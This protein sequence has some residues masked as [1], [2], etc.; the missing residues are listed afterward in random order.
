M[1]YD[2]FMEDCD[3]L[4]AIEMQLEQNKII[5]NYV[6]E[7]DLMISLYENQR[8]LVEEDTNIFMIL[9]YQPVTEGVIET[10]TEA[11]KKLIKRIKELIL[12]F[13]NFITGKSKDKKEDKKEETVKKAEEFVEKVDVEVIFQDL[14]KEKDNTE[15]Y[16]SYFNHIKQTPEQKE[17]AQL[18]RKFSSLLYKLEKFYNKLDKEYYIIK[19]DD[20]IM[21]TVNY[22]NVWSELEDALDTTYKI[23]DLINSGD[24]KNIDD[25]MTKLKN[26]KSKDKLTPSEIDKGVI[27]TDE[28][29]SR[30]EFMEKYYRRAKTFFR[31]YNNDSENILSELRDIYYKKVK[32]LD[33]IINDL[34]KQYKDTNSYKKYIKNLHNCVSYIS[35]S[36]SQRIKL[37]TNI[38][39]AYNKYE[40]NIIQISLDTI[41]ADRLISEIRIL[42]KKMQVI[43]DYID[44]PSK[45][46][47]DFN[48]IHL[49]DI[50]DKNSD[51]YKE[52][53]K[54]SWK[55]EIEK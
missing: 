51:F 47:L 33:K 23:I 7:T 41:E 18:S 27:S 19:I 2:L 36:C 5:E 55:V 15:Q 29:C 10:I 24:I 26:F 38:H 43:R 48:D 4:E 52:L 35:M 42:D 16:K 30:K 28:K 8:L 17:L 6:T 34:E 40:M 1:T 9:N 50:D 21:R 45:T 14:E 12:K 44:N 13:I 11:I 46:K 54:F 37:L 53:K 25:E 49:N 31:N 20:N 3:L 22:N 32:P 39:S